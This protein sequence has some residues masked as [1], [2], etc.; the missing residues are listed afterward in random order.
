[1]STDLAIRRE[2]TREQVELVKR[3]IAP[4]GTS[5]DELALFVAQAN[6]TGLDPFARQ[7]YLIKRWDSAKNKQVAQT[8]LSIDGLRLVA[9][10]TTGY[11]GQTTP[12]WCGPD[13]AWKEVWPDGELPHA[14]RVGVYRHGHREPVYGLAH[15][16]EYAQKKKDGGL[17]VMWHKMPRLMLAKCAEALALRKAFPQELSGLY[18]SEEMGSGPPPG[19]GGIDPKGNALNVDEGGWVD[20][21]GVSGGDDARHDH[22]QVEEAEFTVVGPG[23]HVERLLDALDAA[24]LAGLSGWTTQAVLENARK[25]WGVDALDELTPEQVETILSG[26][27]KAQATAKETA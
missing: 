4:E 24:I 5:D 16:T 10:R 1:M 27:E 8:Q 12:E 19:A 13:G 21:S 26:L 7:I 17:T 11:E 14:A 23:P 20:T 6:R 22:E 18:T 2:L 15:W 3:T 25:K 9:E